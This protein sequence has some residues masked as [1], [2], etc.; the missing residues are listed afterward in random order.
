MGCNHKDANVSF[1]DSVK[2]YIQQHTVFPIVVDAFRSARN[3]SQVVSIKM[4]GSQ[5]NKV[6]FKCGVPVT[7]C[8]CMKFHTHERYDT[9]VTATI[10]S[11]SRNSKTSR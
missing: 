10:S 4:S 7:T 1:T 6:H 11:D 8:S 9:G 3:T 2:A 5:R